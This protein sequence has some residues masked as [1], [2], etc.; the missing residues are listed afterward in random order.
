MRHDFRI[1]D[2]R[3]RC[4]A[5]SHLGLFL[6]LFAAKFGFS[7]QKFH[8]ALA[9]SSHNE[10]LI[11]IYRTVQ[12]IYRSYIAQ[13]SGLISGREASLV[14]HEA[15]L[16]AILRKNPDEAEEAMRKHILMAQKLYEQLGE[17]KEI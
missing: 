11:S 8:E 3:P 5:T 6:C 16:N 9:E 7:D 14:E 4:S 10:F 1:T 15:I 12:D 17:E 2:E 13:I